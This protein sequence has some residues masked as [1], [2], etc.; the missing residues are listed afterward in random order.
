MAAAAA[1]A[2]ISETIA[3]TKRPRL[4]ASSTNSTTA[5][6][7][8]S[9]ATSSTTSSTTPA[10]EPASSTSRVTRQGRAARALAKLAASTSTG[11]ADAESSSTTDTAGA[12]DAA[13]GGLESGSTA[14][15]V[16]SAAA[17]SGDATESLQ[18][19]RQAAS[20]TGPTT[21]VTAT[22]EPTSAASVPRRTGPNA[23]K[24]GSSRRAPAVGFTARELEAEV[25]TVDYLATLNW[26][27]FVA[28]KPP[29][30]TLWSYHAHD[31]AAY[32][33]PVSSVRDVDPHL[34]APTRKPLQLH[35]DRPRRGSLSVFAGRAVVAYDDDARLPTPHSDSGFDAPPNDLHQQHES[36]RF[37]D[38]HHLAGD[39]T[40]SN[41][42]HG[43]LASPGTIT[44]PLSPPSRA[45]TAS[46]AVDHVLSDPLSPT[47]YNAVTDAANQLRRLFAAQTASWARDAGSTGFDEE[48]TQ[49]DM[50]PS[51]TL[52]FVPDMQPLD[53][54]ALTA[55]ASMSAE[56]LTRPPLAMT[57][58]GVGLDEPPSEL[59]IAVDATADSHSSTLYSCTESIANP[60]HPAIAPAALTDATTDK[61][62]A[63]L[64]GSNLHDGKETIMAPDDMIT[65]TT[66]ME[67]K[68]DSEP[69]ATTALVKPHTTSPPPSTAATKCAPFDS[70]SFDDLPDDE[71]FFINPAPVIVHMVFPM[72]DHHLDVPPSAVETVVDGAASWRASPSSSSSSSSSSS[73]TPRAAFRITSSVSN[74]LGGTDKT[75]YERTMSQSPT[76]AGSSSQEP[77]VPVADAEPACV[78]ELETKPV[79]YTVQDVADNSPIAADAP[80]LAQ[81]SCVDQATTGF[82]DT[83]SMDEP[84]DEPM[85]VS[86]GEGGP[87][88]TQRVGDVVEKVAPDLLPL[89]STLPLSGDAGSHPLALPVPALPVPALPAPAPALEVATA[90]LSDL[91]GPPTMQDFD[92][93]RDSALTLPTALPDRDEHVAIESVP[94]AMPLGDAAPSRPPDTPQPAPGGRFRCRYCRDRFDDFEDRWEHE[95]A[96][97]DRIPGAMFDCPAACIYHGRELTHL[98]GHLRN[99]P[100]C[101][102]FV[103]SVPRPFEAR[104]CRDLSDTAWRHIKTVAAQ[105]LYGPKNPVPRR[106]RGRSLPQSPPPRGPYGARAADRRRRPTSP[107]GPPR[108][109]SPRF[110]SPPGVPGAR[111]RRPRSPSPA[112]GYRRSPSPPA[113]RRGW[114]RSRSRSRSPRA[115][116]RRSPSPGRGRSLSGGQHFVHPDYRDLPANLP[117]PPPLVP[118]FAPPLDL[119]AA[120]L[121]AGSGPT[122]RMAR[123]PLAPTAPQMP[124]PS[125]MPPVPP[126][127]PVPPL[128]QQP[129]PGP[130]D[131][132]NNVAGLLA[133]LFPTGLPPEMVSYLQSAAGVPPG[134]PLPPPPLPVPPV[135]P[136]APPPVPIGTVLSPPPPP[137]MAWDPMLVPTPGQQTGILPPPAPP[138]SAP[139]IPPPRPVVP[140]LLTA[141]S[142]A[143]GNAPAGPWV[144]ASGEPDDAYPAQRHGGDGAWQRADREF[145]EPGPRTD[146][147]RNRSPPRG[148][149]WGL[150]Y[151]S[152]A[153]RS[154]RG[155]SWRP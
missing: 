71:L 67:S 1:A 98:I 41:A 16:S 154:R 12:A 52:D 42:L 105:T 25:P 56:R 144:G 14:T 119:T 66:T 49:I 48:Q 110:R 53:A 112:A 91:P 61:E 73:P 43:N 122:L 96:A 37:F 11:A 77:E 127:P 141:L 135:A 30:G 108:T 64:G 84:M 22:A 80:S 132:V 39:P 8:S 70:C 36:M 129:V 114:S 27:E 111:S 75:V 32:A 126:V 6:N 125:L 65:T 9:L 121:L 115:R 81:S 94:P 24:R 79:C 28:S 104:L 102:Q 89:E 4:A 153:E 146:Q 93:A 68:P 60:L 86:D 7:P 134:G 72:P 145:D 51:A 58:D 116:G 155:D 92:A 23:K 3:A 31:F 54:G 117:P 100:Q 78:Q 152:G 130:S 99:R 57:D 136:S 59:S 88:P 148:T 46:L 13:E 139:L 133:N 21:P 90:V 97:H 107:E 15:G 85:D 45:S 35:L 109:R 40:S 62:T 138:G 82:A 55:P 26:S 149:V 19:R 150:M 143:P 10:P 118:Q 20:E 151:G 137:P 34:R 5:A 95:T 17:E 18:Q 120:A 38:D 147:R 83:H 140:D 103:L 124:V 47:S 113:W 50:D 29:P 106:M 63:G 142:S 128:V 33:H 76:S 44:I 123:Q 131:V 87:T 2:S 74:Y 69:A 101:C